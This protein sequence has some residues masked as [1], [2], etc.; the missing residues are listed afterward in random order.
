MKALK[1]L[2]IWPVRSSENKLIDATSGKLPTNKLPFFSFDEKTDFYRCDHESDFHVLTE[3]GVTPMNEL[4]LLK[5]IVTHITTEFPK[6]SQNYVA[7]LRCVL[8]LEN[9]D[10]ENYLR[11]VP[12]LPNKPLTKFAK[13]STSSEKLLP[14]ELQNDPV[15][16]RALKRMGLYFPPPIPPQP[17]VLLKS[18]QNQ[19]IMQSDNRYHDAIFTV[20]G[21]MIYASRYVLSAASKKFEENFLY[22][23]NT[24]PIKIEYQRDSF[25]AF[26]QLLYG[27]SFENVINVINPNTGQDF[28]AYVSFLVDLL[29][30]TVSY[31]VDPV[32][33]KVEVVIMKCQYISVHYLYNLY[34]I[35]KCLE[36]YDVEQRLRNF[37]KP[38]IKENEILIK[39][40]LSEMYRNATNERERSEISEM[41]EIIRM[42]KLL[43]NSGSRSLF[44]PN[45][46]DLFRQ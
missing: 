14:P 9:E 8:Y 13:V 7:F 31:E 21:E 26:L 5:I 37:Y 25:C 22:K 16:L 20:D 32:R 39:E 38:H 40:Q 2:P 46:I 15:C 24:E 12:F 28:R 19:L 27:Q 18:L 43:S 4:E 17:D 42:K 33:I 11:R 34:E 45:L 36:R 41:E 3:L 1:S 29:K 35:L 6:P 30:L 23:T 10:I 44:R